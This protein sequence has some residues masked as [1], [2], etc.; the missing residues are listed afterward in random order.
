MR[1]VKCQK[2]G[3]LQQFQNICDNSQLLCQ[4]TRKVISKLHFS[5]QECERKMY[6]WYNSV[7]VARI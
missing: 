6:N 4:K 2:S 1:L 5:F 3:N 7:P